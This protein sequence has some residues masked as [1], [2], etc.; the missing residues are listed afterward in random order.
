M[1]DRLLV[2]LAHDLRLQWRYGILAAYMVVVLMTGVLIWLLRDIMPSWFISLVIFT[3]NAPV[4]FFF[5]GG[6]LM[7]E[8][9]ENVRDTLAMT[10]VSATEYL[11]AKI[12]T[13]LAL[14]LAAIV[15]V[16]LASGKPVNW[17]LFLVAAS[18][19]SVFYL[20]LGAFVAAR[21]KTV[22]GY[23]TSAVIWFLP[24]LLPAGVA[25]L[26]PMPLW[27][28]LLPTAAQL[29]LIIAALDGEQISVGRVSLLMLSASLAAAFSVHMG[30]RSLTSDFGRKS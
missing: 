10:P 1:T 15:V 5:L 4:G 27:M 20:G 12:L 25:F 30:I 9:A 3:D 21:T 13:F 18:I 16:G 29:D 14:S 11:T 28:A 24:L 17:P 6:L 22:T 7:L 23:V 2:L 26:G 8:R 19:T